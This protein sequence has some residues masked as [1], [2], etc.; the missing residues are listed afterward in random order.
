MTKQQFN[1]RLPDLTREQIDWLAFH[2]NMTQG[3][4]VML[5]VDRFYRESQATVQTSP[6]DRAAQVRWLEEIAENIADNGGNPTDGVT[7]AELVTF[8]VDEDGFEIEWPEWFGEDD[9]D[10]A[11]LVELVR[12]ALWK[13]ESDA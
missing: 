5:A 12:R 1:V 8:A 10:R 13:E 11:L 7:A 3:E 9:H 2:E 4:V 6:M